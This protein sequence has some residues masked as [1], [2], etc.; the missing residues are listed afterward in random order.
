M[1]A[2]YEAEMLATVDLSGLEALMD[3]QELDDM[4]GQQKESLDARFWAGSGPIW[5][6]GT[7]TA[8]P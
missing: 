4:A 3:Q 7:H 2:L 6:L 1:A 5:C 8:H